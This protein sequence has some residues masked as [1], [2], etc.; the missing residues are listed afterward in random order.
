[1]IVGK[2]TEKK[3]KKKN[4]KKT[5]RLRNYYT[6]DARGSARRNVVILPCGHVRHCHAG[7]RR[8]DGRT[9][10]RTRTV[11]NRN[12][13]NRWC[14]AVPPAAAR[15]PRRRVDDNNRTA[16]TR[17]E[18]KSGFEKKKKKRK[19]SAFRRQKGNVTVP[20]NP[21][22]LFG[23]DV[24]VC[25][26]YRVRRAVRFGTTRVVYCEV[27]RSTGFLLVH[28]VVL[29]STQSRGSCDL[30]LRSTRFVRRFNWFRMF[31]VDC[32]KRTTGLV[33]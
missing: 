15:R 13:R 10:R 7:A 17:Y 8:T 30:L 12:D 2:K 3:K 5:T 1:M 9:D 21:D 6:S 32:H 11:K 33:L 23:R 18:S 27:D 28:P 16:I 4:K 26:Y 20:A 22:V 25:N 29:V 14:C 19:K 24:P 31:I